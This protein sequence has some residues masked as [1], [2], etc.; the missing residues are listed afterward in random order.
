MHPAITLAV[1]LLIACTFFVIK[2]NNAHERSDTK[3][4]AQ[5]ST[6]AASTHF[7]FAKILDTVL[8]VERGEKYEDPLDAML[9]EKKLGEVTGGGTMQ[10]KDKSIE[11]VG[12]DIELVNLGSALD[13]TKEKLRELGAPNGSVLEFKL[14]GQQTSTP[15]HDN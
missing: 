2:H 12:I 6:N 11:Y 15:I 8:P 7:V 1:I 14:N 4:N 9:R 5:T 10:R 3:I 13:A